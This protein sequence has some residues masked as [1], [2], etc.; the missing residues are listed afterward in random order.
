MAPKVIV[1][2]FG[3]RLPAEGLS[4]SAVECGCDGVEII[5]AV[6][7]E[8]SSF[9]EVLTQKAVGVLV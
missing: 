6:F 4:W 1:E 9:R 7:G 2:G 3:G 5:G 8:V